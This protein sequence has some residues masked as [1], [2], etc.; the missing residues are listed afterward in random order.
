VGLKAKKMLGRAGEEIPIEYVVS[1]I[2]G[3]AVDSRDIEILVTTKETKKNEGGEYVSIDK[4]IQKFTKKSGK[5]VQTFH[6]TTPQSGSHTIQ[7]TA[8][9]DENRIQLTTISLYVIGGEEKKEQIEQKTNNPMEEAI[10][11]MADKPSY[12]VGDEAEILFKNPLFPSRGGYAIVTST[13][14]SSLIPITFTKNEET[15]KFT[16][17]RMDRGRKR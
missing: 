1:N 13:K 4:E 7:V 3:D 6:I 14:V 5:G 8:K 11:I 15:V 12:Q 2:K 17:S 16:V 9:D 10:D